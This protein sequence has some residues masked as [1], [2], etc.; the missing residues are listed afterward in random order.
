MKNENWNL[1]V[2]FCLLIGVCCWEFMKAFIF[3]YFCPF[4]LTNILRKNKQYSFEY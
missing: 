4:L 2:E 3:S 1:L